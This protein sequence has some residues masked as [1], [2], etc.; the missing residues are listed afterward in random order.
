MATGMF[1]K[2]AFAASWL[3]NLLL[4]CLVSYVLVEALT[5]NNKDLDKEMQL[6][7]Y[8]SFIVFVV[9]FMCFT[10]SF[11]VFLARKTYFTLVMAIVF[12]VGQFLCVL[13]TSLSLFSSEEKEPNVR[14]K[15]DP[16]QWIIDRRWLP[17]LFAVVFL[18][19][20]GLQIFMINRY[21]NSLGLSRESDDR[22]VV[23]PLLL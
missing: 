10:V 16:V 23:D 3:A 13:V 20:F 19:L 17:L 6:G 4:F 7:I 22:K 21:A 1:Y 14:Y 8:I 9:L 15:D 5:T 12:I 11:V 18:P 2:V